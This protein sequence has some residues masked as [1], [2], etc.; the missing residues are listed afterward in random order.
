YSF[1]CLD[2]FFQAEDGIRYFHV[3]GVQTCALPIYAIIDGFLA[4]EG[5]IL[6]LIAP[7]VALQGIGV[8]GISP[9]VRDVAED[10]RLH[11]QAYAY[12]KLIAQ[13]L[14]PLDHQVIG[15]KHIIP[16]EPVSGLPAVMVVGCIPAVFLGVLYGS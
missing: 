4:V 1:E 8:G 13:F 10:K 2:F 9:K 5:G 11:R 7:L 3:T 6:E 15:P 16:V 14:S 12:K